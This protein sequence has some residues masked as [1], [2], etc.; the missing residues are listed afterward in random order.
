MNLLPTITCMNNPISYELNV[1]G[2]DITLVGNDFDDLEN[3]F[4]LLCIRLRHV[5][6]V[7]HFTAWNQ[8]K[9]MHELSNLAVIDNIQGMY[10]SDNVSEIPD[11]MLRFDVTID[12]EEYT[13]IG[14]TVDDIGTKLQNF[15]LVTN[16]VMP[17]MDFMTFH[18]AQIPLGTGLP[19]FQMT[20]NGVLQVFTGSSVLDVKQ[21]VSV[22]CT[23]L[24]I[25]YPMY[26]MEILHLRYPANGVPVVYVHAA[27]D[28]INGTRCIACVDD[29]CPICLNIESKNLWLELPCG[30][31]MHTRCIRKWHKQN[32]SCPMCRA[33][34]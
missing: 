5:L 20:V 23:Q 7:G 30:H 15:C 29:I 8:F 6:T 22:F 21:Q 34:V 24:G 33:V 28:P 13:F 11:G 2:E 4:L 14:T 1:N 16:C 18:N 9:T 32:P 3:N 17:G 12:E 19:T 25:P 26:D 10:S 31:H 27:P